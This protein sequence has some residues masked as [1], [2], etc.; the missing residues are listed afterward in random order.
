M[1]FLATSQQLERPRSGCSGA[2]LSD[3]RRAG[4]AAAQAEEMSRDGAASGAPRR[5]RD[6]YPGALARPGACGAEPAGVVNP[7]A[8]ARC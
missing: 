7:G 4:P 8:R 3:H 1:R 2:A 6:P 5:E